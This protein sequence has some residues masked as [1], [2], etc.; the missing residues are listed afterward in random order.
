MGGHARV[1]QLLLGKLHVDAD[2]Y[3][4]N[5]GTLLWWAASWGHPSVARMLL[6]RSDANP[7]YHRG[8]G[9]TPLWE[10]ATYRHIDV[11]AYVLQRQDIDLNISSWTPY[12]TPLWTALWRGQANVMDLLLSCKAVNP[13]SREMICS[14]LCRLLAYPVKCSL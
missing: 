5:S 10:A 6:N 1:L 2:D 8:D 4:W 3:K 7:N 14:L 12:N 13:N 11:V 9:N